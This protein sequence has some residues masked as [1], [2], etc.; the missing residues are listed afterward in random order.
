MVAELDFGLGIIG[1][2]FGLIGWIIVGLIAGWLANKVNGSRGGLI[3]NLVVGMIG[4]LIGGFVLGFV[5][6]D[7]AGLGLSIAAAF[8]GALLVNWAY[9]RLRGKRA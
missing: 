5:T 3:N 1:T 4:A 7:S 9:G 6:D 8:V 2:V